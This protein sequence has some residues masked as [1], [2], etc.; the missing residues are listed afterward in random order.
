MRMKRFAFFIAL[1]M[2]FAACDTGLVL[3]RPKLDSTLSDLPSA[4]G[5]EVVLNVDEDVFGKT[6]SIYSKQND[7]KDELLKAKKE[8]GFENA[9]G[10]SKNGYTL[11]TNKDGDTLKVYDTGAFEYKVSN[12]EYGNPISEKEME[13]IAKTAFDSLGMN[14]E[15]YE[16]GGKEELKEHFADTEQVLQTTLHFN[17]RIDGY[18]TIGSSKVT[19]GIANGKLFSVGVLYNDAKKE[20]DVVSKSKDEVSEDFINSILHIKYN[21]VGASDATVKRFEI[22]KAEVVYLDVFYDNEKQPHIQP[23]YRLSGT[24]TLDNGKETEFTAIAPAV[25]DEYYK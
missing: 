22:T 19:V 10:D 17:R 6:L 8:Y 24:V 3:K 25:P 13:A 12:V 4:K 23:C 2:L 9:K 15:D 14:I 21:A 1:V 16:R 18:Q 5:A 7:K 20:F 11:Y